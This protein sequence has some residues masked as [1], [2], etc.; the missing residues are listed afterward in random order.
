MLGAG[1]TNPDVSSII[2]S[3]LQNVEKTSIH[4]LKR[5]VN[6]VNLPEN[7]L[8]TLN[9]SQFHDLGGLPRWRTPNTPPSKAQK[10][11]DNNSLFSVV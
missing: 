9:R 10:P 1:T 5:I 4:Q 6:K 8:I 11:D 2:L 3:G 7:H